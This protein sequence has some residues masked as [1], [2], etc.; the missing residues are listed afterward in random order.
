MCDVS[1]GLAADLGHVARASGVAVGL[2]AGRL[3]ALLVDG[4]DLD[5]A[6]RGGEDH[7][8]AA[9]V[10]AGTPLPDGVTA[11]GRV[12]PGPGQVL[13]DGEPVSGGWEH[14]T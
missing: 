4:V 5:Q 13:L 12:D 10:P 1:D 14:F 6:L 7:G 3:R 9:T 2:H 11:V 8:L